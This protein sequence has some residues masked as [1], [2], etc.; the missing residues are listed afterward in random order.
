MKLRKRLSMENKSPFM[1]L[2]QQIARNQKFMFTLVSYTSIVA[3][4]FNSTMFQSPIIGVVASG[5]YWL[6]NATFI[7]QALFKNEDLLQKFL[8]GN[9]VVLVTLGLVGWTAMI[10]YNLDSTRT[11]IVLFVTASFASILN[12]GMKSS[13]GP[14]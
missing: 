1:N 11:A 6:I 8:L 4:F 5:F 14:E 13:Y 10:L 9:L 7:G 3:I 12:I 2:T